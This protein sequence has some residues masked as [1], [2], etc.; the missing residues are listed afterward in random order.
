M[1]QEEKKR[2]GGEGVAPAHRWCRNRPRELAE[3]SGFDEKF[4][5]LGDISG[6]ERKRG[7][8][9]TPGGFYRRDGVGRGLGFGSI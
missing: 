8:G 4:L 7:E 3:R 9:R 6:E 2:L 1:R 5:W